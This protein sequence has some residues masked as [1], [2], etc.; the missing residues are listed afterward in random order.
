MFKVL[1]PVNQGDLLRWCHY[2]NIYKFYMHTNHK[3]N[4]QQFGTI[5]VVAAGY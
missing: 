5:S 2:S 1:A 3:K 4:A